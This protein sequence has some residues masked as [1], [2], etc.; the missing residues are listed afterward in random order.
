MSAENG[1]SIEEEQKIM[2]ELEK[3]DTPTITNV[4]ATYPGA[5]TCMEIY[6]PWKDNWYTDHTIRSM[7]PEM[8]RSCGFAVT[9]TYGIPGEDGKSES[10]LGFGDVLEAVG[11][12]PKP[13]IVI[14]KQTVPERIRGKMGLVGG[15]MATAF[16][17]AGCIG[18]ISDGPS[19]DV[20]EVREIGIQYMLSGITPGHG[21]FDVKSV[22][23][24][25]TVAGMDVEPGEIIHMDE[26]GAVKFPRKYLKEVLENC[27]KLNREEAEKMSMLAS[28]N[29]VALLKKYMNGQ[30]K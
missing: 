7:Y 14:I 15:N 24:P 2:K 30:Y 9:C 5:E 17:S 12:S 4:V 26:N 8:G 3:F 29:D 1:L 20:D 28:T 21:P 25:V 23:T 6:D 18:V 27:I 22:N 16:K 13:V 10:G 11:A 19:R